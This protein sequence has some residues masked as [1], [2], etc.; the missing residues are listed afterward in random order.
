MTRPTRLELLSSFFP[1]LADLNS[2]DKKKSVKLSTLACELVLVD[3]IQ[4][5]DKEFAK[6]GRG[7]L[8]V[9]IA[10]GTKNCEYLPIDLLEKDRE[11]AQKYG[12]TE[13]EQSLSTGIELLKDFN[14]DKGVILMLV[15]ESRWGFYA[16]DRKY[17]A[18]AIQAM[19]EEHA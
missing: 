10:E 4:M 1:E 11:A 9:R 8:C 13:T 16:V 6:H 12:D 18:R 15:D 3:Q 19:L 14:F 5:F 17:P 7:V 2:S